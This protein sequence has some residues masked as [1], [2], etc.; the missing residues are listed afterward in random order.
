MRGVS[1]LAF[2]MIVGVFVGCDNLQP[3]VILPEDYTQSIIDQNTAHQE[4]QAE[5]GQVLAKLSDLSQ[6]LS[7]RISQVDAKSTQEIEKVTRLVSTI[8][9]AEAVAA[10]DDSRIAELTSEIESLKQR[11]ATLEA[12]CQ[13]NVSTSSAAPSGGSTGIVSYGS[14]GSS[15]VQSTYYSQSAYVTPSTTVSSTCVQNLDGT[16]TCTPTTSTRRPVTGFRLWR[17]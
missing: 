1:L 4:I 2:A 10:V 13:C 11:L 14:S 3:S 5:I 7:D 9:E 16:V 17:R 6:Q 12:R 8:G 15:A